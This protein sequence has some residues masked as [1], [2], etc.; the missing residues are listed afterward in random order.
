M[1]IPSFLQKFGRDIVYLSI[2]IGMAGW[3]WVDKMQENIW[4]Q[5]LAVSTEQSVEL[6]AKT[7]DFA[8][9][10]IDRLADSYPSPENLKCRAK[11]MSAN[12]LVANLNDKIIKAQIA[13]PVDKDKQVHLV[14]ELRIS[15]WK[16]CDSLSAFADEDSILKIKIRA[17]LEQS[18][19]TQFWNFAQ[20]LN[21]CSAKVALTTLNQKTA[22]AFSDLLNYLY[23]RVEG[24][25][26]RFDTFEPMSNADSAA[27]KVGE[28]YRAKVFLAPYHTVAKH[29]S[30]KVNGKILPTTLGQAHFSQQFTSPGKKKYMV[31]IDLKNPLTGELKIFKKEFGLIVIDSCQ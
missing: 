21:D 26:L 5:I 15:A 8:L 18:D 25:D 20:N 1:Q 9:S 16:L 10:Q 11:A 4:S 27:I 12:K 19:S 31:E 3:I 2:I 13:L 28:T 30:I 6:I 24:L 22:L 29:I 7:N 17:L 14:E 23:M